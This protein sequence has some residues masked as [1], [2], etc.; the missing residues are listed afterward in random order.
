MGRGEGSICLRFFISTSSHLQPRGQPP[1][2]HAPGAWFGRA[3]PRA[4]TRMCCSVPRRGSFDVV[5]GQLALVLLLP[6]FF[7]FLTEAVV[8]MTRT[9][10]TTEATEDVP[11]RRDVE[12]VTTT[13]STATTGG[14]G[15][16]KGGPTSTPRTPATTT[17]DVGTT[18]TGILDHQVLPK[19][20]LGPAPPALPRSLTPP[21]RFVPTSVKKKRDEERKKVIERL[22]RSQSVDYGIPAT[23]YD[24]VFVSPAFMKKRMEVLEKL[25]VK[26]YTWDPV[27]LSSST[28][29]EGSTEAEPKVEDV[30]AVIRQYLRTSSRNW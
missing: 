17:T 30:R 2:L 18:F 8:L 14:G 9:N 19:W 29:S 27:V 3:R 15:N 23:R 6:C 7:F 28:G 20:K 26:A 4:T 1:G 24:A 10:G 21:G 25:V 16:Y 12:K 13:T 11:A 22:P 5:L